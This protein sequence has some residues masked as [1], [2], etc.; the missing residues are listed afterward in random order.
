LKRQ[1]AEDAECVNQIKTI[2]IDGKRH[3]LKTLATWL[4]RINVDAAISDR[5]RATY[6]RSKI[7]THHKERY[8]MG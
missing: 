1:Q 7:G 5:T 4:T 8:N 6:I 2:V 3:L